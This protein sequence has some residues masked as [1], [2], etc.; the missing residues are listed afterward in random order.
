MTTKQPPRQNFADWCGNWYR[1]PYPGEPAVILSIDDLR[2]ESL[3]D[4]AE[5]EDDNVV[6]QTVTIVIRS[7]SPEK[8]DGLRV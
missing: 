5:R 6:L 3:V 2:L 7:L 4:Q 1:R 8:S